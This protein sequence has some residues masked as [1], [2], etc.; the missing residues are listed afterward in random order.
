MALLRSSCLFWEKNQKGR[1]GLVN[2]VV[3]NAKFPGFSSF[4]GQKMLESLK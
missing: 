2:Y 3:F 1:Q 4:T